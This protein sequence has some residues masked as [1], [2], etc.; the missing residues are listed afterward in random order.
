MISSTG[1]IDRRSPPKLSAT[2]DHCILKRIT[3]FEFAKQGRKGGIECLQQF[4]MRLMIIRV[5][6]PTLKRDLDA[7]HPFLNEPYGGEAPPAKRCIAKRFPSGLRFLI[8]IKR[9]ELLRVHHAKRRIGHRLSHTYADPRL[10]NSTSSK[11]PIDNILKVRKSHAVTFI[12][13]SLHHVGNRK[14]GIGRFER[15]ESL[16]QISAGTGKRTG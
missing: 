11:F 9:V 8:D 13:D 10:S 7:S 4:G 3:F 15:I 5:G 14:F 16:P 12:R 2:N 1:W 6:I